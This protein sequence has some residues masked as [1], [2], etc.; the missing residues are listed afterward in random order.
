MMW[1]IVFLTFY[2]RFL[3]KTPFG[4]VIVDEKDAIF[5]S[6]L[7]G[8]LNFDKLIEK[9]IFYGNWTEVTLNCLHLIHY[10]DKPIKQ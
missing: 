9:I 7:L 1:T 10:N 3:V 5:S 2:A 6:N 8:C 4:K